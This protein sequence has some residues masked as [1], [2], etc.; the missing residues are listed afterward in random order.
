MMGPDGT[1]MAVTELD[2]SRYTQEVHPEAVYQALLDSGIFAVRS[3]RSCGRS[4]YSPRVLCPHCGSTDL[5]WQ[6][7]RGSGVVYSTSTVSRRGADPV[8][9]VLVDVDEGFRLMSNVVGI[10]P[11]DVQIGMRVNV[12]IDARDEGA[13]PVFEVAT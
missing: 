10:P 12:R 13:V 1:V 3:C 6:Q 2:V 8:A 7:S 5:A 11:D 4:H 9:V